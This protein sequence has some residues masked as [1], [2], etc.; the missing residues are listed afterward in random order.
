MPKLP[1]PAAFAL[2]V[3]LG[4]SPLA[5]CGG[6]DP[7]ESRPSASPTPSP[8]P[9][10][11]TPVVPSL[12]PEAQ[13]DSRKGAVAFVRHYIE[14]LNYAQATGHVD[15][16]VALSSTACDDC[17]VI[18]KRLAKLYQDGGRISGGALAVEE[19]DA[20][21]NAA[22]NGWTLLVRVSSGEQTVYETG[23]AAPKTLPG[24]RRSMSFFVVRDGSDWKVKQWSRA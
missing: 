15:G 21:R 20:R 5:G 6:G 8:T 2:A 14:L 7:V 11:S 23:D 24:G 3:M 12:P 1:R 4:A 13:Q 18:T 10:A 9:A 19:I 17:D 22:E 16:V